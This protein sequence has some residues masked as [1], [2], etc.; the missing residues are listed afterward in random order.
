[1]KETDGTNKYDASNSLY[2]GYVGTGLYLKERAV[3]NFG[4]RVENNTQRL[5]TKNQSDQVLK[6]ENPVT[7]VL[8][9]VNVN[10]NFSKKMQ[11]RASYA[12]TINRP[13]FRDCSIWIL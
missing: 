2:A 5:N 7:N 11:V 3:V 13:E 4:V 12:S 8:P 9:S 10:Y 1:M 6:V